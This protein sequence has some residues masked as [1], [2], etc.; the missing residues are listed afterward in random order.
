MEPI[1]IWTIIVAASLIIE[2]I[3]LEMVSIWLAVGGI[4]GLILCAFG[5]PIEI[6]IIVAVVIAVACILG[7]RK[8]ALKFLEKSSKSKEAEILT[9]HTAVVTEKVSPNRPGMVKMNGVVWTAISEQEI[10]PNTEVEILETKGN[11]L[12]VKIKG[13]K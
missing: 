8:F 5:V 12:I 3:T 7:L 1:W 4:F 10:E 9:G 13:D 11:K 6:Q 2:F